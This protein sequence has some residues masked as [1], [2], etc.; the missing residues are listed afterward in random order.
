MTSLKKCGSHSELAS[1]EAV[2]I[3]RCPCGTVHVTLL[4][5][6]VTVQM[7]AEAFRNVASGLKAASERLDEDKEFGLTSIN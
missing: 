5:P 3:T 1:N 7:A 2:R 6:G 4:G